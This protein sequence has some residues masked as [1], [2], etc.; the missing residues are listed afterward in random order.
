MFTPSISVQLLKAMHRPEMKLSCCISDGLEETFYLMDSDVPTTANLDW[1]IL[2]D[3]L[4]QS[5]DLCAAR[6]LHLPKNLRIHADNCS[7]ETRNQFSFKF[8][9]ILTYRMAFQQVCFTY[10]AVGHSHGLPDQRFSEVR[11]ML[12]R[13]DVIQTPE[14]FV[15][16]VQKVVPR[17]GRQLRSQRLQCLY[18]FKSF[19][20]LLDIQVSG[21]TSTHQKLQDNLEVCHSFTLLLRRTFRN[22]TKPV[23]ID[24]FAIDCSYFQISI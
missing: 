1:T 8:G 15:A 4:E 5:S 6:T 9:A 10:F 7:A 19:T 18:D 12:S 2:C 21:H 23:F 24:D 14:D 3:M 22:L 11:A 17:Q 13:Q 16:A 20:D